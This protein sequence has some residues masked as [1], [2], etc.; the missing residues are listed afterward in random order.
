[1]KQKRTLTTGEIADYCGVNFRTVIRWIRRGQLRAYQL[2]GRGDNRVEIPHFV[3][4]LRENDIPIP[5]EFLHLARRVLVLGPEEE[6]GAIRAALRSHDLELHWASDGFHAGM[7][8]REHLPCVLVLDLDLSGLAA[9]DVVEHVR[10]TSELR[11]T[12]ILALSSGP[13]SDLPEEI[14]APDDFLSKPYAPADLVARI[15]PLAG[16]EIGV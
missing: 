4:F 6:N 5:R 16:S 11:S 9:T 1:M 10:T 2:P 13:A 8:L 12:K 3:S 15:V 14:G 7:L